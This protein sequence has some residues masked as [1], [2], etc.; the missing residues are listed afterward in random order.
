MFRRETQKK[1]D[2]LKSSDPVNIQTR[3]PV[4]HTGRGIFFFH[5]DL[6]VLSRRGKF[7]KQKATTKTKNRR[8]SSQQV[9]FFVRVSLLWT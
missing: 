5:L 7:K 6:D 2:A 8:S 4:F 3:R 9:A 1:R